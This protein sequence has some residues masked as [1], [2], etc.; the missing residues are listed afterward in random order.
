MF[1]GEAGQ[2]LA[3]LR[4]ED[5]GAPPVWRRGE[6]G[7]FDRAGKAQPQR[8]RRRDEFAVGIGGRDVRHHFRIADHQMVAALGFERHAVA[9]RGGERLR[10]GAGAD[11]RGVGGKFAGIGPDRDEAPAVE[12]EA[13][14]A[15]RARAR[16]RAGETARRAR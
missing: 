7:Q 12:T 11:D 1:G 13:E 8:H 10:M 6:P 5:A 4:Q 14:R 2:H 9:E 3:A 16:R 15:R